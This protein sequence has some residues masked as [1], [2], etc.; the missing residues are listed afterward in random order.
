[1]EYRILGSGLDIRADSGECIAVTRP[2]SRQ[3]VSVLALHAGETVRA[4][5]LTELLW[6][7][8]GLKNPGKALQQA[9]LVARKLVPAHFLVTEPGGYRLHLGQ[10]DYLDLCQ[11]EQLTAR[12]ERT[13]PADLRA[14]AGLFESALSLWGA[15][16][17]ADLPSTAAVEPL[18]QGLLAQRR[19]AREELG[20][21]LL[22]LG[23]HGH[24]IAKLRRWL[25]EDPYNE[26][27]RSQ[28]MLVLYRTEHKAEALALYDEAVDLMGTQALL[29]P[30]LQRLAQQIIR[31]EP[32]LQQ[33]FTLRAPTA[34]GDHSS[35]APS[36]LPSVG[37]SRRTDSAGDCWTPTG[38]DV[39][40]P[41]PA[42]IYD[43]FLGGKDNFAA[44]R[45][46][47]EAILK[48]AP[49]GIVACQEN[50]AFL[51]R[52]VEYLTA[53]GVTQFL[54]IGTGLPTQN[55]VHE[56]AQRHC[57]RARIVYVDN[58]P[59][60]S[61]HARALLAETDNV[62]L[63]KADL[64][65]P[66]LILR[67]WRLQELIDFAQP[68]AILLLA[69]LHFIPDEDDPH[70]AVARLLAEAAPGSYLVVSHGTAD[71]GAR[72]ARAVERI[73][74]ERASASLHTRSAAEVNRFFDGTELV[75]PGLVFTSQWRPP[76]GA[77]TVQPAEAG[78][79][80]GIGRKPLS[81]EVKRSI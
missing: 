76:C 28:L 4:D 41:S 53:R 69:I 42:R 70:V 51:C 30:S 29:G 39:S 12:A 9:V 45:E 19:E 44:D 43:W 54:D 38:I 21:I 8:S 66:E 64:R 13:R 16:P 35:S 74:D 14:A 27:H 63:V 15:R 34:S 81:S 58:D 49:H 36:P 71:A 80:A 17:L 62:A 73:Y 56:V 59:I 48:A 23:E 2:Q 18:R 26:R 20:S 33:G 78:L 60:V 11:F 75:R 68:V 25:A 79:Y 31:N 50:R 65:D 52:A 1:M 46:A 37:L 72:T 40:R 57:P 55:N 10:G 24:L 3:L 67:H 7:A 6:G 32:C 61:V 22:D 5:A 47:G 77:L